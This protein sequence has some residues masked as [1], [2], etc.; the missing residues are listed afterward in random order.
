MAQK[1]LVTRKFTVTLV[2]YVGPDAEPTKAQVLEEL[3][4]DSICQDYQGTV[5]VHESGPIKTLSSG[6]A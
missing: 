5:M 6:K 4:H 1:K 3:I 2:E